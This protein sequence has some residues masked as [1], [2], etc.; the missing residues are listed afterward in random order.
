MESD[1]EWW[2][3]WWI[4][5]FMFDCALLIWNYPMPNLWYPWSWRTNARWLFVRLEELFCHLRR[6]VRLELRRQNCLRESRVEYP[7]PTSKSHS[8]PN[9]SRRRYWLRG[10]EGEVMIKKMYLNVTGKKREA[11][12][13]IR[14]THQTYLEIVLLE[15]K[16]WCNRWHQNLLDPRDH[17]MAKPKREKSRLSL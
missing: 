17:L 12:K 8:Q 9:Q 2:W 14:P 6:R 3:W 5:Y 15:I 7:N 4:V 10:E 13:N 1:D 11:N 16:S